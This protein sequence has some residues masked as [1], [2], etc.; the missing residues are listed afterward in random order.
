MKR[1]KNN[2]PVTGKQSSTKMP[3]VNPLVTALE[4]Q[5]QGKLSESEALFRQILYV[6]PT[7]EIALYS[8]SVMLLNSGRREEA[9][10]NTTIGTE[11]NPDFAPLW[12]AHASVLQALHRRD[13]A[14][15][16]YERALVIN[17]KYVE[18]LV[19]SG[20]L[21]RDMRRHHDALMRFHTVLEIDPEYETAL[22]NYGILLTEF[23][24]GQQAVAIFE[25]LLKKN[26]DYPYGLGLLCYERMHMCDWTDLEAIT[27][28]IT[29]GIHEGRKTC[30]TLG[31]MALSDSASDHFQCAKI[32]AQGQHPNR[33]SPLWQGEQYNHSRIRVAY[34]SPDLREHPV[35][36]LMAGVFESHDKSRFETIAI[37]IGVDDGSRLRARMVAAFDHFIDAKDMHPLQIAELMKQMEVDIAVDLA[38]YTS[39]AKTEIFLNRPAPIQVNY[40]GY[41]GTLGLECFD[42]IL[43]DKTVIPEEHQEYYSEKVAYI[44]HCYLPVASGIEVSEPLSRSS[45]GLPEQG[46][47]FCAFSHDYK[48]HPKVFAVWMRLL[49]ASPGSVLWLVSRN[50]MSQKNLR[51][52]AQDS[53]INPDRLIFASR[54]PKVEDH[55]ARYRVADLF[56]DTWP[57]NAHTTAADALLAGLPVITYKGNAFPARVA[58]SLLNALGFNQL[59]TNSFEEYFELANG[60]AHDPK[61]LRSLKKNLSPAALQG[62]PFLGASFT[63][64]LE[65]VLSNLVTPDKCDGSS[66]H[67]NLTESKFVVR[68][69]FEKILVDSE[70]IG[71]KKDLQKVVILIPLYKSTFN[72]LEQFSIDYLVGKKTVRK[73]VFIAPEGLNRDYYHSRYKEIEFVTFE[74]RFFESVIG[75]NHLLLDVEFYKKFANYNYM[76]IHQP[77][78]LLLQDNLDY[79]MERQFDYIGAP[80]PNGVEMNI[81][82]GKFRSVNGVNLK[83][84]VGNGGFSL[85]SIKG[86]IVLLNEFS[87]IKDYWIK[88]GNR[89]DH[90]FAF[91]GMLSGSY[92]IPNQMVASQFSL[93][94]EPEKYFTMNDEKVPTGCHAWWKHDLEFWKK[95]IIRSNLH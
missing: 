8:L 44:E 3:Q 94:V 15:E 78:A 36:H 48:I 54:V 2:M 37:S 86:S 64:A 65:K 12:F 76:L 87:E 82:V 81:N 69:G 56:L 84:Y 93:E 95:I 49:E 52:A 30:K 38:G 83:A 27:R 51:Q 13:E 10:Q 88:N 4:L 43:A 50:E 91:M 35:G 80:W 57:Y 70:E 55:L 90:F 66:R 5:Q 14:L 61:R 42:Y 40:L 29:S 19:N 11:A 45:Y 31:Y 60:L 28:L 9:L 68:G 71:I 53:C 47:V 1:K 32:F 33:P 6:A 18:V 23:K 74:N 75:Y 72:L 73:L 21:L 34:V 59:V 58:A 92:K 77:D 62:H 63:R 25:R 24:Q 20:A 22:S 16:S 17:P 79:W 46:F 41:P 26:P 85:R 39:D 7:N 89:E 67:E